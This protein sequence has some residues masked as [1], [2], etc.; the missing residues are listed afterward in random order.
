MESSDKE[1]GKKKVPE[2]RTFTVPFDLEAIKEN[3]SIA[4]N[5]PSKTSKKQIINQAFKYHSQGNI[6]EAAKHY[7]YFMDQGFDD[8]IVF[9]NYG[10]ILKNLG[11]L[12]EAELLLRNAIEL[13]PDFAIAHSNLGNV[14]KD[15]GN[16]KAAEI[17]YQTAIQLKPDFAEAYLNLGIIF[18]DL[19]QLQ[20][21]EN[22]YRK[23]IELNP[24][25]DEAHLNLGIILNELGKLKELINFSQSTIDSKKVNE[26]YKLL[27]LLNIVI[28]KLLQKE[29]VGILVHIKKINSLISKGVVNTIKDTN[30][31]KHILTYARFIS[32]LYPLLK[33]D[34]KNI[35]FEKIPHFG[36]SHCLSFAHQYLSLYSQVKSI[37]PVLIIGGK[38]WNFSNKKNN[39]WKDSLIQQLKNHT[40]SNIVFISFGEIDCRKDEGILIYAINNDIDIL[41][42]CK[43]TINGYLDYM[44]EILSSNY[45]QRYYFGVP[46]PI[47]EKELQDDLDIKRIEMIKIYNS[48][49]KQEVLV[50]GS[51][52]LDV[53]KLTST[54]NGENNNLY[55]CDKNHLSPKCLSILFENYLCKANI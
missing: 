46:A 38:A 50:R 45:S 41:E 2:V 53:Y 3:L 40:Y 42:V 37:Q 51:F 13:N 55:M 36:E 52:F 43:N 8:P 48:L 44:E 5:A 18:K 1:Q 54:E 34:N 31:R 49:L 10:T 27:A 17:S 26:G 15:L 16:L 20:N 12:K 33:K 11:K 21:A 30:T 29:F 32:S 22:S 7:Q 9:S 4:S 35:N 28:A 14:L 24:D 19:G 6:Q 47:R 23:A 39:K 25:L